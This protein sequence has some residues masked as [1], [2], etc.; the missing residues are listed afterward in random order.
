MNSRPTKTR[1]MLAYVMFFITFM[2][3]M[4]RVNLS[5]AAP[6]IMKEFGFTKMEMGYLQTAFFIGYSLM[7]VPG[8]IMTELFG[9]RKIVP[10]AVALWSF[11]T[12]LTAWCTSLWSFLAMRFL[13]G[14][15]EG[16][17]YPAFNNYTARWFNKGEKAKANAFLVGGTFIGPVIGP[18]AT[19]A[20]IMSFGWRSAFILFGLLGIIAGVLWWWLATDSPRENSRVNEA[21]IAHIE[22]GVTQLETKKKV[23]PWSNFLGSSQFWGIG[24]QYFIA[25]YIMYVF[26]AWLPL[27]LMEV[28]KF[29]LQKMG[30]AASLPWIAIAVMT[31]VTGYLSDKLVSNGASKVKARSYFGISGLVICCGALYLAAIATTPTMNVL[32][33]TISLGSLGMT[34]NASWTACNDIGGQFSASVSGWMNLCGNLGGVLAPITTAWIATQYGWQMA[35]L[36]TAASAIVGIVAWLAVKPDRQLTLDSEKQTGV[37]QFQ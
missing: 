33:M 13:F 14:I 29:S 6:E 31:F 37:S 10:I 12:A 4:D 24:I 18:V 28:H 36:V 8:G 3:Y 23:A 35:L 11:F 2:V 15:G 27:Y 17:V 25:D 22:S 5:V 21:E 20:L 30:F 26:L 1:W 16:P 7:Q 19:V 9:H 34:F 32:W